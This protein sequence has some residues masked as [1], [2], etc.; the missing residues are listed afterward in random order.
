MYQELIDN[1]QY[2]SARTDDRVYLD[3]RTS[4]RYTK[5]AE[6]LERNDSK[7]NLGIML[8]QLFRMRKQSVEREVWYIDGRPRKHKQKG[9]FLQDFYNFTFLHFYRTYSVNKKMSNGI[10]NSCRKGHERHGSSRHK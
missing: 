3:L 10:S 8:K 2:D 4:S 7:I 1:D 5:G 6:E 9:G